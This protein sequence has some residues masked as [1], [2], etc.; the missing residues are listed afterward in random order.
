MIY[1]KV[2]LSNIWGGSYSWNFKTLDNAKKFAM[3]DRENWNNN[4][5]YI[6][7]ISGTFSITKNGKLKKYNVDFED[8]VLEQNKEEV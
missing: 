3:E 4:E 6:E 8:D 2:T 1:Y 5:T 7:K